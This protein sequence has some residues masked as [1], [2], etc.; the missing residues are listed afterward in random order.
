MPNIREDF[1]LNTK[2]APVFLKILGV[3]ITNWRGNTT[4]GSN[5][6]FIQIKWINCEKNKYFV[7]NDRI[8]QAI[9]K[10][11]L[12]STEILFILPAFSYRK[13]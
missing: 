2:G 11:L 12:K 5:E 1:F 4:V 8:H 13:K 10:N 6:C 9:L 3:R 7:L